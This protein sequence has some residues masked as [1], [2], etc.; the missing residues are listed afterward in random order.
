MLGMILP[1]GP[2]AQDLLHGMGK[3]LGIGIVLKATSSKTGSCIIANENGSRISAPKASL[4]RQ[5]G[6][7]H[8]IGIEMK[9][10][11][12]AVCA[13][14]GCFAFCRSLLVITIGG[15]TRLDL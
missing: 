3:M 10:K 14:L 5:S 13:L 9:R 11:Y 8:D 12:G 1:K 2:T 15:N 7:C 6:D 4:S